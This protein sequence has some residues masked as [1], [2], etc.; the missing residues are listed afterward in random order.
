MATILFVDDE[1]DFVGLAK[2]FLER[3]SHTVYTA[4]SGSEALKILEQKKDEIALLITDIRMPGMNGLELME[5]ALAL[6]DDLQPIII[7]AFGDMDNVVEAM[8]QGAVNYLKK[9]ID[10]EELEVAVDKCI[11]KIELI[12][13]L[14]DKKEAQLSLALEAKEAAEAANRTRNEFLANMN[15]ELKTPLNHIIGFT[16]LLVDKNFGDLNDAQI[17]HLNDVL[18]SGRHLLSLINDILD[19]ARIGADKL[20]LALSEVNLRILLENCL[21]M[22]KDKVAK[23]RIQLTKQIEDIPE[24]ITADER[25]LKQVLFNI[26]SNAVKFTPDGGKIHLTAIRFKGMDNQ[27]KGDFI[28]IS[29]RDTGKGINKKDQNCI[30]DPFKQVDGSNSRRYQGAGLGL[31][32]TKRLIGLHGGS[33]RVQSEG[34]GKGSVFHLLI[35]TQS[36]KIGHE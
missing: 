30:F 29:I 4:G 16:Q 6:K 1:P 14:E 36:D 7:T 13:E 28:E 24:I 3:C 33:I 20:E 2:N 19:L 32:L 23:H 17:E 8:R 18:K 34:E 15:H 35:P 27:S 26:L 25:R 21:L 5:K 10:L 31:A 9:P 22:V 12:R 11:E